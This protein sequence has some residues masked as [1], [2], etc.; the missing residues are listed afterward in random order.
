MKGVKL[1]SGVHQLKILA[2]QIEYL[3]YTVVISNVVKIGV[4]PIV[5]R[6]NI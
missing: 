2:S 5:R 6:V 1:Y 4:G 3:L